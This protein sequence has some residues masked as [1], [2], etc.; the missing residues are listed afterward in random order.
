MGKQPL[1]ANRRAVLS[2]I[3]LAGL[4][5]AV[6]AAVCAAGVPITSHAR[7]GAW[8]AA[9]ANY[10]RADAAVHAFDHDRLAATSRR[11]HELDSA[12]AGSRVMAQRAR[13]AAEYDRAQYRFNDLVAARHDAF[14]KLCSQPAPDLPAVARK[15]ELIVQDDRWECDDIGEL[16]QTVHVDLCR[17]GANA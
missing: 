8:D 16:L 5:G 2:S 3:A 17:L 9:E 14:T 13:L 1:T 6:P 10:A 12:G 15:V 7:R 4:A 11:I